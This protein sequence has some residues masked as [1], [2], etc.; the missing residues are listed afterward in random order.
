M[1]VIQNADIMW[2]GKWLRRTDTESEHIWKGPRG[3]IYDMELAGLE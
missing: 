3:I 2:E 1:A